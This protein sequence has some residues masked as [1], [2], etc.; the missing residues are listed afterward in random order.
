[1]CYTD[2]TNST[3]YEQQPLEAAFGYRTVYDAKIME[4]EPKHTLVKS[5]HLFG[6]LS[7]K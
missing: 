1:M 4:S 6:S 5:H 2:N 7:K 3:A